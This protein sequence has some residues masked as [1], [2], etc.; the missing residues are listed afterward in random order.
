ME[1]TQLPANFTGVSR[2]FPLPNLVMFP[3]VMQP[4]HIF[5]PRYV[6]MVEEAIRTD[7]LLA[8]SILQPGWE[9]DYPGRPAVFPDVCLGRIATHA[10]T[11]DGNYNIL[12]LG[13]KRAQIRRELPPLRSFR[14][15]EL[16][17]HDD[18]YSSASS[19][20]REKLHADLLDAFRG[21][22][23]RK[24]PIQEQFDQIL[25]TS[26]IP[27]GMLT[28]MVSFTVELPVASKIHLLGETNVDHRAAYLLEQLKDFR[29]AAGGPFE[30][31]FPPEFSH[32]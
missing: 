31:V 8:M 22:I 3:H 13:V 9:H 17:L 26:Q 5:E 15:A 14:Q 11:E 10:K 30:R 20:R 7:Q 29:G 23:A 27:L 19:Q 18:H 24:S 25:T 32:N 2:L 12:L 16:E 21:F 28:D 1:L 4:L 6:E